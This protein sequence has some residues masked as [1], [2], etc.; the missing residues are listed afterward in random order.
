MPRYK[1]HRRIFEVEM[2][3]LDGF[4]DVIQKHYN[5]LVEGTDITLTF[6][7]FRTQWAFEYF[8]DDISR[9][10]DK[11]NAALVGKSTGI[12]RKFEP[13]HYK[14][15]GFLAFWLRRE[16]PVLVWDT[17]RV[18]WDTLSRPQRSQA[19]YL[20][21]YGR[22]YGAFMLGYAICLHVECNA[23]GGPFEEEKFQLS[24][25]YI[26]D[27]MAFLKEKSVSPHAMYMIYRSIFER[28]KK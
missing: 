6:C 17:H 26:D 12:E 19:E 10:A 23:L 27:M 28:R 14:K 9:A 20:V 8:A 7:P 21:T 22:E 11:M 4:T 13:D 3:S 1:I 24:D 18:Q 15:A 16:C 5:H 25:A 2:S